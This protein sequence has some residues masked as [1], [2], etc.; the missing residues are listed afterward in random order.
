MRTVPI[1][2]DWA[3]VYSHDEQEGTQFYMLDAETMLEIMRGC[4]LGLETFTEDISSLVNS[5]KVK[6]RPTPSGTWPKAPIKPIDYEIKVILVGPPYASS[7]EEIKVEGVLES[8]HESD[9]PTA[10]RIAHFIERKVRQTILE[11]AT[12][13]QRLADRWKNSVHS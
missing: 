8:K 4:M 11:H 6:P 1:S 12:A 5:I 9:I 13:H 10:E 3:Q 2:I 7:T